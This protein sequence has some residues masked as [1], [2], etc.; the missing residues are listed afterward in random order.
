M[1][2][3]KGTQRRLRQVSERYRKVNTS[4]V[5][6][7]PSHTSYA[8]YSSSFWLTGG[9][10]LWYTHRH[11][12]ESVF[13]Y[14]HLCLFLFFC[15]FWLPHPLF[16][17]VHKQINLS[18]TSWRWAGP[19]RGILSVMNGLREG[20]RTVGGMHPKSMMSKTV[21]PCQLRRCDTAAMLIT[22]RFRWE[23]LFRK[24][25][26]DSLILHSLIAA[27]PQALHFFVFPN[28]VACALALPPTWGYIRAPC[29]EHRVKWGYWP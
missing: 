4:S 24:N 22:S 18:S 20:G 26:D 25:K 16:A 5:A 29:F 15:S 14:S 21:A 3:K 10:S 23:L 9:V 8:V 1:L 19:A 11:T 17:S 28:N 27:T 12:L 2:S 7:S 6:S 13:L